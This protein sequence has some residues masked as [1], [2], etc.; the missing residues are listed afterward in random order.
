MAGFFAAVGMAGFW[1][2]IYGFDIISIN[3][4]QGKVEEALDKIVSIQD[5]LKM[6]NRLFIDVRTPQEFAQGHL[7]GAINI[8]IFSNE[9]RAIVGTLYK[10]VSVDAAKQRGLEFVSSKLPAIIQSISDYAKQGYQIVIYCWRGGMRSKSIVALLDTLDIAAR[11][12][13]GGYK[14]YRRYIL[15]GLET[16]KLRSEI[17]VLAGSTGVGKTTILKELAAKG[18]PTIDLEGLANHRGSVFGQIGLGKSTTMPMFEAAVLEFL[19]KYQDK[20]YIIVECESSQIG[21]VYIPKVLRDGM[22]IGKK[23]LVQASVSTRVQRI[24]D[25]YSS[26]RAIDAEKIAHCIKAIG[27]YLGRKKTDFLLQCLANNQIELLV[28]SLLV[29]Y[30]DPLYGYDNSK[31]A[32]YEAIINAENLEYATAE[33]DTYLKRRYTGW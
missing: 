30:Y 16:Y 6:P 22:S 31:N 15:D 23:I 27:K 25:E 20:P 2:K 21:N 1:C 10:Q 32:Q 19:E 12:L 26:P 4:V 33:L 18:H 9:E 13:I 14:S 24:I 8:P 29:D 3:D 5:S 28:S 17:V 11:Q 7:P